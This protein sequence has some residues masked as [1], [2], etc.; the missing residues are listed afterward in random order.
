MQKTDLLKGPP[1]SFRWPHFGTAIVGFEPIKGSSIVLPHQ[2]ANLVLRC[3]SQPCR[4]LSQDSEKPNPT[5]APHT[6][7]QRSNRSKA[8]TWS[9]KGTGQGVGAA[10]LQSGLHLLVAIKP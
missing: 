5:G 8:L 10:G 1:F 3:I 4:H 2:A 9:R 7:C 6:I